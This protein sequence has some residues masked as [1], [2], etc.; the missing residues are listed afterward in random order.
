MSKKCPKIPFSAPLD[1]FRHFVAIPVFWAVQRFARYK[2]SQTYQDRK[3][4]VLK[5]TQNKGEAWMET[6]LG[7]SLDAGEPGL[8]VTLGHAVWK[9]KMKDQNSKETL[10]NSYLDVQWR[11]QLQTRWRELKSQRV[12]PNCSHRRASLPFKTCASPQA[13]NQKLSRATR[14]ENEMV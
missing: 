11:S 3:K 4:F 9:G 1:N 5:S 7:E 2:T 12:Q 6:L 13:H 10:G 14:Y 8:V